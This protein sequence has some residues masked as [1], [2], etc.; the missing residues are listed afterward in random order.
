MKHSPRIGLT[1]EQAIVVGPDNRVSFADGGC[2]PYWPRRGWSRISSTPLAM[3]SPHASKSTSAASA[4]LSSSS[5]WP[6]AGRVH[7]YLPRTGH[8]CR[9]PGRDVPGRGPRRCRAD[10]ARHSPPAHHRRRSF[11]PAGREEAWR[12]ARS[13]TTPVSCDRM[14]VV[15]GRLGVRAGR[16]VAGGDAGN[17]AVE[18]LQGGL[19][20]ALLKPGRPMLVGQLPDCAGVGGI[21]GTAAARSRRLRF[22]SMARTS[23]WMIMP[24]CSP[25]TVRPGPFPPGSRRP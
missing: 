24:A 16:T 13:V 23:S 4:R 12:V 25:T 15:G 21:M 20:V 8:P 6:R 3:R 17:E 18:Q 10:R 2:L 19:D 9:R 11:C 7:G 14:M 1:G 22:R 5:I